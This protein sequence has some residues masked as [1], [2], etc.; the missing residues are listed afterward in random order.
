VIIE[1]EE[2]D[3][4]LF[5]HELFDPFPSTVLQMIREGKDGAMSDIKTQ[6]KMM[7]YYTSMPGSTEDMVGERRAL[8]TE[9]LASEDR[10]AVLAEIERAI[11]EVRI[12]NLRLP[13]T[14]LVTQE[15]LAQEEGG[16]F[17]NQIPANQLAHG[18][19]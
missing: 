15:D 14:D 18:D 2:E 6:L 1:P 7:D 4:E 12:E 10:A 13:K 16:G 5:D 9:T 11:E 8:A 3:H 17:A 19:W